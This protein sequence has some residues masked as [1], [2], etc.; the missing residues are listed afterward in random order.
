MQKTIAGLLIA[1]G[2]IQLLPVVGVLGADHLADL[3]GLAFQE[4]NISILM[5]H[6]ALLFGLL[7]SFLIYSAFQPALWPLAF[8]AGFVSVISFIAIAWSVG[9]YNDAIRN[10][11]IGD[12]VAFIFLS[13]AVILFIITRRQR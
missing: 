5:R 6:R 4:L 12:L 11:V 2:V 7:G 3:Y 10:V 1:V 13:A 8:I 9:S